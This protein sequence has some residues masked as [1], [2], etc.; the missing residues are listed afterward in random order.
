M[1]VAGI[2]VGAR[3]LHAVV[4][5]GNTGMAQARAF[6]AGDN[7]IL[8]WVAGAVAVGVDAPDRWSTAPH[9]D[10]LSLPPKFRSARCAEIG[11]GRCH[12]IWVP[13]TTPVNPTSGS[14]I[15]VGI[16]LFSALRAE[17][18][19][20]LEAF[21][22]A[23]FRVLNL[24]RRP[25]SKRTLAGLEA[26]VALLRGAGLTALGLDA[27]DHDALDAAA[28]AL[29]ALRHTQGRAVAATC[30]HDGSAIWLPR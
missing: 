18:H 30:G 11:L 13:W 21:P 5:D 28:A 23:A 7:E 26:R 29:V 16:R 19:Q 1:R 12:R 3:Q 27:W 2:D 4:L 17:G 15:D 25:P 8:G 9:V 22:H 14:W 20:P 6:A 24:R 10:N